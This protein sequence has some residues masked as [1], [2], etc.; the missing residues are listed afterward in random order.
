MG[1]LFGGKGGECV[2][3]AKKMMGN[4][5][6]GQID[7]STGLEVGMEGERGVR[8]GKGA[9]FSPKSKETKRKKP[10]SRSEMG[11]AR[12]SKMEGKR[13][14]SPASTN[15]EGGKKCSGRK[16]QGWGG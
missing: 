11:E 9:T 7:T 5:K 8:V 10:G 4:G 2:G 14:K 6:K 1:T 3:I 13:K 16:I 15:W 12:S